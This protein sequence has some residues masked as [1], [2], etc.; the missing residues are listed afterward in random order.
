VESGVQDQ[1][2]AL[3]IAR[4]SDYRSVRAI[5]K[6][7]GLILSPASTKKVVPIKAFFHSTCGG[8]TETPAQV[9]GARYPGFRDRGVDCPFCTSSPRYRWEA[10][11]TARDVGDAIASAVHRSVRN[12]DRAMEGIVQNWPRGWQRFIEPRQ[13]VGMKTSEMGTSTRAVTVLVTLQNGSETIDLPIPA[14][15]LREW[16][17]PGKIR[18]T[19]FEIKN[20]GAAKWSLKGKGNGHGVG[21]CQW[22][23][24]TMGERGIQMAKILKFYYPDAVIRKVW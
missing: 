13:A 18:S 16:L 1:V 9:W 15:R 14:P 23:A 3:D 2:F 5:A 17:G 20:L 12:Q 22:G 8:D 11:V 7:R 19:A 4:K 24:K 6:T 10:L 21:M